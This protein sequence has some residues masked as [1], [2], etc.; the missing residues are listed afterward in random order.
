MFEGYSFEFMNDEQQKIFVS[1]IPPQIQIYNQQKQQLHSSPLDERLLEQIL[2]HEFLFQLGI[3]GL[4]EQAD[5]KT[6][7]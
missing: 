1:Y 4:E 5:L 2:S 3:E 7:E 6:S